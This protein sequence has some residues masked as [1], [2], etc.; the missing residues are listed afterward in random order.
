MARGRKHVQLIAIDYH[1]A[2]GTAR[3]GYR[4][5]QR[6]KMARWPESVP[7]SGS[8]MKDTRDKDLSQSK[9]GARESNVDSG[10]LR[11]QS[12]RLKYKEGGTGKIT[13]ETWIQ[14]KSR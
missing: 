8:L 4:G 9:R 6:S 3:M 13:H 1:A 14:R 7:D 12:T 10:E 11:I 5:D 2:T